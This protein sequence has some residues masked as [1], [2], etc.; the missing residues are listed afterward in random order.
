MNSA[1]SKRKETLMGLIFISPGLLGFIFFILIPV[2]ASI[3]VSFTKWNFLQGFDAMTFVGL[4]NYIRMFSDDWFL[5]SYKN[6]ILFTL[7][8]VPVLIAIGLIMAEMLNRYVFGNQAI[9]IMMFIPYIASIVAVAA[10]WQVIFHPSYGP[11][12]QFLISMGVEN[13]PKWFVDYKW[14]LYTIMIV[15]IWQQLGYT[16]IV[17]IA[18]LK[19]VPS[20]LYEAASIDGAGP[21]RQFLYVTVP[22]VSP[23]TFFLTI[24]GIIGSFRVFDHISLLT[25]GGPGNSSSVMAFYIYRKAFD[26]FQVGYANAL[27]WALF[28]L[29]FIVTLIQFKF[30]SKFTNE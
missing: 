28:V 10:V 7:I 4:R 12:N 17:Y 15:Y 27:A 1:K 29:I 20:E 21:I 3:I 14:S 18:G 23:T 9:R 19:S 13:P 11:V 26:D 8:T 22:L 16:M 25:N 30:Q 5:V 2:F 6:N 24:M